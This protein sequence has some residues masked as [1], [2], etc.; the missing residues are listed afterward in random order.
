[1]PIPVSEATLGCELVP[2]AR[3]V[4]FAT[5]RCVRLEERLAN[6]VRALV[7]SGA[8]LSALCRARACLCRSVCT[9]LTASKCRYDEST[10][11]QLDQENSS[12]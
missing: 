6:L 5:P 3:S 12:L 2:P 1:M 11:F 9:A 10:E 7:A 4:L 8:R